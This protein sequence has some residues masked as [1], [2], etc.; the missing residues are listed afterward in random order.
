MRKLLLLLLVLL[1]G[2]PS[3]FAQNTS[4]QI[5]GMKRE[6]DASANLDRGLPMLVKRCDTPTSSTSADG[7]YTFPCTDSSNRLYVN[8]FGVTQAAG[9][10]LTVRLTDGS[11]FASLATDQAE[12]AVAVDGATGPVILSVRRNAAV[13][14][15]SADGDYQWI[16]TDGNGLLW[17]RLYDPC[18]AL[19]KTTVGF[20]VTTDTVIVSALSAKK[21]YLCNLWVV[22]GAAEIVSLTEGTGSVCGTGEVALAGSTTDANGMSFAAN[23]GLTGGNGLGSVITGNS[24]NVDMCLNVSGSNRVSGTYSYVQAP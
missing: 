14:S 16:S 13:A 18:S 19:P 22:A 15:S 11:S 21:N 17:G 20:S 24:T 1:A 10:Y 23:G 6:D 2:A 9:T 12:D 7:D 5:I 3:L 4:I 8:P